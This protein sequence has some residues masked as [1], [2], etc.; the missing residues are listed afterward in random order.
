[1]MTTAIDRPFYFI[2]ILIKKVSVLILD[3]PALNRVAFFAYEN[4]N[5]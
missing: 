1:M 5:L 3:L 2:F 4:R